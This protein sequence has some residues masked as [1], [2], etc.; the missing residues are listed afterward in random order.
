MYNFSSPLYWD[1]VNTQLLRSPSL[2]TSGWKSSKECLSSNLFSS[3]QQSYKGKTENLKHSSCVHVHIYQNALVLYMGNTWWGEL[4]NLANHELF[5]K[6]FLTNI[7][8]HTKNVLTYALT[9]AYSPNFSLPI[10][11]ACTVR[12]NFLPPNISHVWYY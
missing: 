3:I 8:R 12:Q 9:V 5:A 10:A 6:I 2:A 7:H 1:T 11:F 4:K